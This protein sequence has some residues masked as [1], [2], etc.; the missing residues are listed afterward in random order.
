MDVQMMQAMMMSMMDTG[1]GGGAGRS[2]DS[3]SP[4][5]AGPAMPS[6]SSAY[7]LK[8]DK[9]NLA[10]LLNVLDGVVDTPE[11][12]VVM[13]T[14]HPDMLD[15]ALVRPGRIDQK[16]LLGYMKWHNVLDMIK[17]YF[18]VG[19]NGVDEATTRRVRTAILGNGAKGTPALNLTPAQVEQMAAEHET[20]E[21]MVAALER[22]AFE[23]LERVGVGINRQLSLPLPEC[24]VQPHGAWKAHGIEATGAEAWAEV[25]V[26]S[27]APPMPSRQASNST[28][29]IEW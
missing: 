18:Q 27:A 9:L 5:V 20:V 29:T 23:A 21:E 7:A 17:H 24:T 3:E 22:K 12:L 26:P 4:I 15:P 11:R 6:A 14:N 10:G 13:T 1:G 8:K 25:C 16:L 19:D 28:V 2:G